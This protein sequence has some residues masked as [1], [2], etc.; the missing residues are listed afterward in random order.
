MA[1]HRTAQTALILLPTGH[2]LTEVRLEDI[3]AIVKGCNDETVFQ[4]TLTL[5]FPYDERDA[6]WFIEDNRAFEAQHHRQKSWALR[7]EL[8]ELIGVI[9]RQFRHGLLDHKDE[10]GYWLARPYW[11]QGLMT[12]AVQH[13]TD[14][15]MTREHLLRVEAMVF[16]HN[17]ASQRVLEKAG[18]TLEGTLRRYSQKGPK[19]L[20]NQLYSRLAD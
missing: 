17:P 9:G 5:P 13:Y 12:L 14:H 16:S 10:I 7:T 4:N 8:G 1:Y 11:G 6:R 3:A 2:R 19:L 18:Y 20:D 15:L